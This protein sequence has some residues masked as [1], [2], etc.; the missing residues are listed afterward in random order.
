LIGTRFYL[1]IIEANSGVLDEDW[2]EFISRFNIPL[3][4][5][6]IGYPKNPDDPYGYGLTHEHST[7]LYSNKEIHYDYPLTRLEINNFIKS[8]DTNRAQQWVVSFVAGDEDPIVFVPDNVIWAGSEPSFSAGNK[9]HIVF[10]ELGD[11]IVGFYTEIYL[12]A[13][14]SSGY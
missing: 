2:P 4:Y 8:Y 5:E 9:Y 7:N 11:Y 6:I 13:D 12:P 10:K 14:D 1:Y 3:D